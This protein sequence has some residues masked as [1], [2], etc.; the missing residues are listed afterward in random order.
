[1]FGQLIINGGLEETVNEAL[2]VLSGSQVLVT[3]NVTV[4]DPPV[5]EFGAPVLLLD[6]L[7]LHPP[8]VVTVANQ[9]ENLLSI[10]A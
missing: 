10:T 8:L 7:G 5:H 6:K 2:Q 4:V 3:V 9:I 1:M